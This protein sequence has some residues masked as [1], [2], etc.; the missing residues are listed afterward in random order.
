M[1][2]I[3]DRL[4]LEMKSHNNIFCCG[5]SE[6]N[7]ENQHGQMFEKYNLHY[8]RSYAAFEVI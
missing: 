4:I 8:G 3:N 6:E 2:I 1:D 7:R 5:T